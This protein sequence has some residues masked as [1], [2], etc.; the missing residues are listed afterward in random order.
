MTVHDLQRRHNVASLRFCGVCIVLAEQ[1]LLVDVKK[2]A[3]HLA[4]ILE[5]V[6]FE[7]FIT[8]RALCEEA[9]LAR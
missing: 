3:Y 4:P 8:A 7:D 9:V 1:D 2:M 5:R 6:L